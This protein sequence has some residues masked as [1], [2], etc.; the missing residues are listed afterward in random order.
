MNRQTQPAISALPLDSDFDVIFANAIARLEAYNKHHYRPNSYL[1]KWWA[2]RCGST[3]RLILKQ[4]VTDETRREYYEPGGLAGKV[5]LD[6][7]IGGGTTLHEAIRMG[8][9]VIGVDLDPIPVLQARAR[10]QAA[11]LCLTNRTGGGLFDDGV[12]NLRRADASPVYALRTASLLRLWTG[13]GAGLARLAAGVR[14]IAYP[15]LPGVP[16]N[17]E[18]RGRL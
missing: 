1:H 15:H 17:R 18:R 16:R 2:R 5:I 8:A 6:P 10:F 13:A 9:N 3:F 7:M 12:P 4:L 11:L 14:R